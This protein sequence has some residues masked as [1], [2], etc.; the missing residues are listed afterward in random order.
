MEL[1]E[2]RT[3][4]GQESESCTKVVMAMSP[5]RGPSDLTGICRKSKYPGDRLVRV[6]AN[7][8]NGHQVN[9][10]MGGAQS[11]VLKTNSINA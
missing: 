7:R 3:D 10:R 5:K 6:G 11:H 8:E 1:R 4:P 9:S 2:A